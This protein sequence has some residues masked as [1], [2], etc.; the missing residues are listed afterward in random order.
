MVVGGTRKADAM[1]AASKPSTVC[2]ISGARTLRSMAVGD[3]A[4][5]I[6]PV[7]GRCRGEQQQVFGCRVAG[8]RAALGVDGLALGYGHQPG[9]GAGGHTLHRP[10]LQRGL[11]RGGQR[12]L[13]RRHIARAPAQEG[14]QLAVAVPGS[15]LCGALGRA[16]VGGGY[17]AQIGRTSMVP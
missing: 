1:A 6:A 8:G 3:L 12:V 14:D 15:S 5:R 2:S 7:F 9:L 10:L 16:M 11:E 4:V 17:I 13:R